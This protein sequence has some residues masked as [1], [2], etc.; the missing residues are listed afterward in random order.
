MP[1][2]ERKVIAWGDPQRR[3]FFNFEDDFGKGK[4]L[5]E[6][7]SLQEPY[8][9][10]TEVAEVI[11]RH[12]KGT[13]SYAW[14]HQ[15]Y[16]Y[17]ERPE[18]KDMGEGRGAQMLDYMLE[19]LKDYGHKYVYANTPV[20]RAKRLLRKKGFIEPKPGHFFREL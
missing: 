7:H 4:A 13:D 5:V 1:E 2:K 17:G 12:M 3:L 11:A 10:S 15:F 18:E 20:E 8:L 16:P 19:R 6:I 14:I 9:T